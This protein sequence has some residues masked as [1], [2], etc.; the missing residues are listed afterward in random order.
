MGRP[1]KSTV[2]GWNLSALRTQ[3]AG[4]IDGASDLRTQTQTML[5]AAQDAAG[6]WVGE[7][8]R[9][10]EQRALSDQAEINKLGSDIDRAGN[11]LN[12]TANAISPN[13]STALSR[14]DGLEQDDF[15]VDDDWS[16][17]ETRNYAGAIAAAEQGSAEYNKLIAERDRRINDA[18]NSTISLQALADQMGIDDQAGATALADA[19][20]NAEV[21]APLTAGMSRQQAARDVA[22]IAGGT[23]TPQQKARFEA[24]TDLSPE[25]RDALIQ[26]NDAVITKGQFEYLQGFYGELNKQGLEGFTAFG[27]S[28]PAMKAAL[29]DGLQ[30]LSNPHVRTDQQVDNW[31]G[32]IVSNVTG[33]PA[34]PSYI[35]GGLSQVPSAIR[36]PLT[37]QATRESSVT[38]HAAKSS[39]S[40]DTHDF[41]TLEQ[42][43]SI[44]DVLGH[45][46]PNM[47]LGSDIDRA[48]IVRSSEIAAAAID[49]AAHYGTGTE[50]TRF[51][52]IREVLE[53]T[54]HVAG[55]DHIAVHDAL[56]TGREGGPGTYSVM[57][58][59]IN[60]DGT[61]GDYNA[62]KSMADLM[63][64]DWADGTGGEDSGPNNLFKWIGDSAAAPEGSSAN[65]VAESWRAGESGSELTRIIADQTASLIDVNGD[66]ALGEVNPELTRTLA[67]ALAPQLGD[68]AG[69]RDDLFVTSGADKL[70]NGDQMAKLF[71]VLDTDAEAGRTIN[72][73]AAQTINY[74][75]Y[76]FAQHP[77]DN[78][79]GTVAGRLENSMY[80]GLALQTVEDTDDQRYAATQE[81]TKNGYMFDSTKGL[82]GSIPGTPPIAKALLDTFAP[83]AKSEILGDPPNPSDVTPNDRYTTLKNELNEAV[84]PTERYKD[85]LAGYAEKNPAIREDPRF[86]PYFTADGSID[87]AGTNSDDFD[88]HVRNLFGDSIS[89]YMVGRE[90]G[91][92]FDWNE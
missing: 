60:I 59:T 81:Y 51:S 92:A 34:P 11:I 77:E 25:Q 67:N 12:N 48:L 85:M 80:S 7:S 33:Q 15:R 79:L 49:P 57:P 66:K 41:P 6:K 4:L 78:P 70:E 30:L 21:N 64:F 44:A 14:V 37:Q 50:F 76:T 29:A 55:N 58:D 52:D 36:D 42:L 22:A 19:F 62:S 47:Q 5:D 69:A 18:I 75:E 46:D 40:F 84:G 27:G 45:G 86:Q 68:L 26:G 1:S 3:A 87:L 35:R 31:F 89:L 88:G 43:G 32:P 65:T 61:T 83:F 2:T 23:A 56:M 91:K 39:A 73:A 54:T 13:R 71:Q 63:T 72:T 8:Q 9:A 74:L 28:D 10:C 38:A 16:V 90:D 24:A 82:L 20:S 17:H 53:K